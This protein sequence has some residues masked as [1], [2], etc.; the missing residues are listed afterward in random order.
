[1]AFKLNLTNLIRNFAACMN[2][3]IA[4]LM[5]VG[6]WVFLTQD[7]M[8]PN[9]GWLIWVPLLAFLLIGIPLWITKT[10]FDD[11][12][13]K[14]RMTFLALN[15]LAFLMM[16]GG[17]F[18]DQWITANRESPFSLRSLAKVCTILG[19]PFLINIMALLSLLT[20]KQST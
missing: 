1:M 13:R 11:S 10:L 2:V 18:A 16:L 15:I 4:L 12:S 5:I 9:L 8:H 19:V 14:L 3:A 6:L 20:R 7:G 17:I